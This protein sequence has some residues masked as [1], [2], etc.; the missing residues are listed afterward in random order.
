[1]DGR[2]PPCRQLPL[3]EEGSRTCAEHTQFPFHH[4]PVTP[5]HLPWAGWVRRQRGHGVTAECH[6]WKKTWQSVGYT[7]RRVPGML[8]VWGQLLVPSVLRPSQTGEMGRSCATSCSGSLL[9]GPEGPRLTLRLSLAPEGP[10]LRAWS[11]LPDLPPSAHGVTC[12]GPDACCLVQPV[13]FN[14]GKVASH[15]FIVHA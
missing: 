6:L 8:R 12:Q 9:P 1:M 10:L 3:Q 5:L 15:A 14:P 2:R 7:R 4:P 13:L 11:T